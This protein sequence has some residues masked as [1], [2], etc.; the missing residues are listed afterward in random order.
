MFSDCLRGKELEQGGKAPL[1][2]APGLKQK[3]PSAGAEAGK[4][5]DWLCQRRFE[6]AAAVLNPG[7]WRG[8]YGT[9]A[10][11]EGVSQPAGEG[12]TAV[13]GD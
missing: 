6:S 12:K 10:G 3:H 4:T 7:F 11:M 9:A 2:Y 13:L 5:A 8:A 1:Y